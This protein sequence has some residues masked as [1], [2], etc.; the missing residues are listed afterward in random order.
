MPGDEFRRVLKRVDKAVQLSKHIVR[1]VPRC[2]GLAVD[3]DRDIFVLGSDLLDKISE[4]QDR[5]VEVGT[6]AEFFIVD[7]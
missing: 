2:L 6:G 5:R 1:Q 4:V 7:G 3:I